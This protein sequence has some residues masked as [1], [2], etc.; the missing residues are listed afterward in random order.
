MEM[1]K[2]LPKSFAEEVKAVIAALVALYQHPHPLYQLTKVNEFLI[3]EKQE[4]AAFIL[5]EQIDTDRL[6]PAIEGVL[7]ETA[8]PDHPLQTLIPK[9]VA[10]EGWLGDQ[11]RYSLW[12]IKREEKTARLSAVLLY[13]DH[14]YIRPRTKSELT[15]TRGRDCT[16]KN[17]RLEGKIKVLHLKG[18]RVE[19]QKEEELVFEL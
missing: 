19:E 7:R 18:K 8:G 15:G 3:D 9:D 13:E 6:P 11:F 12:V 4:I 10:D 1:A 16:L 17:L 14:A 5:F 2:E